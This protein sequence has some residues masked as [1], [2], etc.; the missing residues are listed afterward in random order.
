MRAVPFRFDGLV[1]RAGLSLLLNAACPWVAYQIL[2]A[3]G[4]ETVTALAVTTIFPIA[5]TLI[6]WARSGHPDV[7]GILSVLFIGI[8]VAVALMTDSELVILL[9]R[10]V[11]NAVL[12]ILCFGSLAFGRPLIFYVA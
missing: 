3:Q 10:S 2:T 5:G 7:L 8:S 9:R 6:G 12:A 11:S 4:V 1:R